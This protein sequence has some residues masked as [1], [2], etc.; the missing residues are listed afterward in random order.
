VPAVHTLANASYEHAPEWYRR[1]R[2]EQEVARGLDGTEDLASPGI[3]RF[4]L[5]AGTADLVFATGAGDRAPFDTGADP[6]AYA[7][8]VRESERTRRAAFPSRLHRS[9]DAYV[10]SRGAGRTIVAGYPWF[11]DWG[12]DTFIA[13]RG[14]CLAAGRI[15]DARRI[16]LDLVRSPRACCRTGFPTT[17]RRRSST[18]WTRRCGS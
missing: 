15:D 8:A 11:T 14:I 18:R 16:L 1:F 2:Y 13:L 17:E 4:D 12:R 5:A 3:F 9:A 7:D 6:H 10:V